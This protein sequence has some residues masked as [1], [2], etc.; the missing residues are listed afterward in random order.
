MLMIWRLAWPTVSFTLV[1]NLVQLWTIRMIGPFGADAIAAVSTGQR[2]SWLVQGLMMAVAAGTTAMVARCWGRGDKEEAGHITEVSVIMALALSLVS[3][4]LIWV[5]APFIA[6]V[7]LSEEA[8]I[9]DT[10][11]FLRTFSPWLIAMSLNLV[12]SSAMRAC[13]E[14]LLPLFSSFAMAVVSVPLLY[15]W[16]QGIWGMPILGVEGIALASGLGLA[17]STLLLL[18]VWLLHWTPL[19]PVRVPR[20]THPRTGA[21][22]RL[23]WPAAAEQLVLHGGLNFFVIIVGYYGTAPYAAYGIGVNILAMSFLVGFGFSIAGSTLVGQALGSERPELAF[24]Y[25]WRTMYLAV[26]CMTVLGGLIIFSAPFVGDLLA[27]DEK[28]GRMTAL[29]ILFLGS[30]QPLMAIE[31]SLGGA[32]RGAGDTRTPLVIT[33]IGLMGVR[34]SLALIVLL[35]GL[36]VGWVF[37]CLIVDYIVKAV[38]YVRQFRNGRWA[39]VSI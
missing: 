8:A 21:L 33:M 30:M 28:I 12:L 39:R 9:R 16:T 5:G 11:V 22:L 29:F 37:A 14:V 27:L 35:V 17:A 2:I 3:C 4:A 20:L 36:P 34:L 24:Q 31:F 32:L 26:A 18:L 1:F 38:L 25:G 10:I 19:P 23:G 13:G 6:G 15:G 7:F